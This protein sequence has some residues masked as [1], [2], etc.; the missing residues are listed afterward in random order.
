MEA[1]PFATDKDLLAFAEYHP[2][3]TIN[4]DATDLVPIPGSEILP[5]MKAVWSTFAP[6]FPP[7][8]SPFQ[9]P[10]NPQGKQR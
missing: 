5:R 6:M 9:T 4:K 7:L 3:F 2:A 1:P 8:S 10:L